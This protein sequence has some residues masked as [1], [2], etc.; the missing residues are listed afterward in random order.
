M[1]Q[2]DFNR[3]HVPPRNP[4]EAFNFPGKVSPGYKVL[5]ARLF[6]NETD[7]AKCKKIL[8]QN[9]WSPGIITN[10]PDLA[11]RVLKRRHKREPL[12]FTIQVNIPA[13]RAYHTLCGTPGNFNDCWEIFRQWLTYRQKE[14]ALRLAEVR[15]CDMSRL[16]PVC[17]GVCAKCRQENAA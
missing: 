17:I 4:Q 13:H 2:A 5:L 10:R 1:N 9:W 3:H 7:L 11:P 6:G 12:R 15:S 16:A 14:Q 8:W